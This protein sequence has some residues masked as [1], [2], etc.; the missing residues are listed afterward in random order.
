MRLML[1]NTRQADSILLREVSQL[2][3]I[4]CWISYLQVEKLNAYVIDLSRI[5]ILHICNSHPLRS[6]GQGENLGYSKS[7]AYFEE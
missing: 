6:I 3:K 1:P 5:L 2:V 4:L 7:G